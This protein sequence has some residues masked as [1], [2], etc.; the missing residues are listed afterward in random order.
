[1]LTNM[2]L[3]RSQLN[4]R[5]KYQF[6]K[7]LVILYKNLRIITGFFL[8]LFVYKKISFHREIINYFLWCRW[9]ESQL[10][11]L[12]KKDHNHRDPLTINIITKQ[13]I[14]PSVL[15]AYFHYNPTLQ[16]QDEIIRV[17]WRVS[18]FTFKNFQ[19]EIGIFHNQNLEE[20][21]NFERIATA[22]LGTAAGSD[23]GIISQE[24]VLPEI[25]IVNIDE[26][27]R[28]IGRE[29]VELFIEDPRAHEGTGR[30]LTAHARFGRVGKNF[31]RM[32][33]I[34]LETN[35]GV[36]V[37]SSDPSKTE[38]NWVVIQELEDS[39]V[40]LNQSKPAIIDKV[41]IKTGISER[42]AIQEIVSR[43]NSKNLNGGSPFV[44]IDSQHFMRV[45]RL[46]FPIY[47]IG[48][49][50]ISVLVLHD[51]EFK[52]VARSKPFIFNKLGVEICN[53]LIVK[54]ESVFFSWGEDDIEMY[55]GKCSKTELMR[56]FNQNIQN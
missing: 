3:R 34:D 54:D 19:N 36:I 45:A 38:K 46:T 17:F 29:G 25:D 50:R 53:G 37:P 23:F 6:K 16:L 30:Y 47:G 5:V 26:V 20:L 39:L 21:E 2:Y 35:S 1:M 28:E 31:Y 15:P 9:G 22:V 42:V 51:L 41:N 18:D 48:G 8:T 11:S 32:I 13:K 7:R 44:K 14:R 27:T 12:Y 40:F 24:V 49:C 4:Q 55:V 10:N 43:A 52:E 56:W 33:V